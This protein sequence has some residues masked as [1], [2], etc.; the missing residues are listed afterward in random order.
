MKW[1]NEVIDAIALRRSVLYLGAGVS[2]NSFSKDGKKPPLWKDFIEKASNDYIE[3]TR[4]KDGITKLI[5]KGDLLTACELLREEVSPERFQGIVRSVFLDPK[6]EESDIHKDIFALDSR[7][8]ATPNIDK[9]Y[10]VYAQKESSGTVLVKRYYDEDLVSAIKSQ[11]RIV[12]KVHGTVDDCSHMIFTQSQYTQMRYKYATF[13]RLLES[14]VLNYTFVFIGCGL[15]DPDIKLVL[16]N[17]A[18][19]FPEAPR[20]YF[21]YS[22]SDMHNIEK[23]LIEKQR[24]IEFIT[25]SDVDDHKELRSGIKELVDLVEESRNNIA[26]TQKW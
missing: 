4:T 10:E 13:Y 6:F 17:M 9:I 15:D 23:K 26:S 1:P 16:E 19:N 25:Y 14:L 24:N 20:H 8:V 22:D 3:D 18:F 7:I 5:E 11:S 2:A 12:L 21:V